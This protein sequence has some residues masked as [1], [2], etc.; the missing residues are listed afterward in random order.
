MRICSAHKILNLK[1]KSVAGTN[2]GEHYTQAKF[3]QY[4]CM[5]GEMASAAWCP[6]IFMVVFN[7]HDDTVDAGPS[8]W[9]SIL[10]K[11]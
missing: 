4:M 1:N 3:K 2:G 6:C 7:R 9:P 11:V 5:G 8:Q 10:Q